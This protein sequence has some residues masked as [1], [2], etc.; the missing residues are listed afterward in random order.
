MTS[1][2]QQ[3]TFDESLSRFRV[4]NKSTVEAPAF[5]VVAIGATAVVTAGAMTRTGGALG[6]GKFSI[7]VRR[8][9]ARAIVTG[10][11]GQFLFTTGAPIAAD[12]FGYATASLPVW[13]ELDSSVTLR[14]TSVMPI[15]GS[16]KL[17]KG[18]GFFTV[19]DLK[20]HDGR[21]FGFIRADHSSVMLRAKTPS[22]GIAIATSVSTFPS[23]ECELFHVVDDG[24]TVTHV[25][26]MNGSVAIKARVCNLSRQ[27]A[28]AGG[29]Y[30]GIDRMAGGAFAATWQDCG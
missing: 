25:A 8:P 9:D 28:V 3:T 15:A 26:L 2:T 30:I 27:G 20:E 5:S 11:P 19:M 1:R 22:G 16:F 6:R 13:A 7:D 24:T 21:K 29:I 18:G 4:K 14:G 17:F 10:S 12:K 23:A